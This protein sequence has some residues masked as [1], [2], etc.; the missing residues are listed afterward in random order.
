[1][2]HSR[3]SS[4]GRPPWLRVL[5][6]PRILLLGVVVLAVTVGCLRLG[7]WQ[8]DRAGVRAND[9]D[10]QRYAALEEA[11]AVPID[12]VLAPQATFTGDDFGRRVVLTG[13]FDPA[14]QVV[15]PQRRIADEDAALVVSAF[16]VAG[17]PHAGATMP[18]L[19]G[20]L[21]EAEVLA[22]VLETGGPEPAVE[23]PPPPGGEHT[24]SGVLNSSEAAAGEDLAPGAVGGISAG[25]LANEWGGPLY[26]GYLVLEEPAQPAGITPAPSPLSQIDTGLNTQSLGYAVEWLVFA[27]F[28]LVFWTKVYRDD[29]TD[30]RRPSRRDDEGG[31]GAAADAAPGNDEGPTDGAGPA[32][33]AD[34][35][36]GAGDPH[37]TRFALR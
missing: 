24:I 19:R 3:S 11:A 23:A 13:A 21:P 27:I 6:S 33:G 22:P 5:L 28:A 18:V 35:V 17:G 1:M 29:L 15:V 7:L 34:P 9:A 31:E 36:D 10:E 25:Q 12:E 37:E 16:V 30:L 2:T 26:S 20:W 14:R 32:D 8:L 4:A